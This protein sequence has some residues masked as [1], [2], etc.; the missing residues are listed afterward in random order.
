VTK[1]IIRLYKSTA[2]TSRWQPLLAHGKNI[3][4]LE[5]RQEIY[6]VTWFISR[7]TSRLWNHELKMFSGV[8]FSPA[9]H[10]YIARL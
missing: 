5:T 7:K 8:T 10:H 4:L 1:V 3:K 9:S 2:N 6:K